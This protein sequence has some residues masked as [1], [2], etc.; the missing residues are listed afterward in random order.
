[1]ETKVGQGGSRRSD[2]HRQTIHADVMGLK[3]PI[4]QT[5]TP[6]WQTGSGSV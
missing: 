5:E 1:M 4:G 2:V 6:D 3:I